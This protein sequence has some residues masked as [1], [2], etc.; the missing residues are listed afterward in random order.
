[1]A[2]L[3]PAAPERAAATEI[4]VKLRHEFERKANRTA[5][6]EEIM[7][8]MRDTWEGA[9]KLGIAE[10]RAEEAAHAVLTVFEVRGLAVSEA[11][12]AR[13]LAERDRRRLE[14]W[15]KR[16]ILAAS[17]AEALREGR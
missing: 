1:L 9:R 13:I 6:E 10:G 5:E 14:R 12:R 7:V 15:H 3:P 16:A 17:V 11:D 2:A 4:V 8:R